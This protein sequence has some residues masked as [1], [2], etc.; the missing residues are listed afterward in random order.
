MSQ[1]I[2]AFPQV[3]CYSVEDRLEQF[4]TYFGSESLGLEPNRIV[5]LVRT[6]PDLLGLQQSNV[7]R[8]VDYLKENGSSNEEIIHYLATSL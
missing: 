7:A 2:L 8:M 5:E 4:F 1:I 3:L 6:R